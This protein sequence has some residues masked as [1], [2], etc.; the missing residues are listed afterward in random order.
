VEQWSVES[1]TFFRSTLRPGGAV[2]TVLGRFPL[3]NGK[4]R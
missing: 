1:V 4:T 2:Y 3:M